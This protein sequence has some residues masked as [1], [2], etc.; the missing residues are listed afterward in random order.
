MHKKLKTRYLN[1]IKENKSFLVNRSFRFVGIPFLGIIVYL[2]IYVIHPNKD[3]GNIEQTWIH[4]LGDIILSIIIAVVIWEG[5]LILNKQIDKFYNWKEQPLKRLLSQI[6]L[7]SIYSTLITLSFTL[8]YL[9][10]IVHCP[11]SLVYDELKLI[12]FIAVIIFLLVDIVY[13]G[14]YFFRQ[15]EQMTMEAEKLKQQNLISQYEALKNQVNPHF[16]FNS[17]NALTTL[18]A[19]D[20][21][22]AIEFVQRISNVYR[23]VL[24]NKDKELIKLTEE[25]QFIKAF[26]FLQKI[27][28]GDNLNVNFAIPDCID[29]YLI[30]PLTLQ[31]LVENAIKHNIISREKP[32]Y[33]S[34]AFDCDSQLIVKNNIQKKNSPNGSIGI[35]LKNI[36]ERYRLLMNKVVTI[37]EIN[38]EFV[39]SVPLIKENKKYESINN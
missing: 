26:L 12:V 35:G 18:I 19:E 13:I 15:W 24:Q 4:F 9:E 38:N 5:S 27:R 10:F 34:I 21:N 30:A 1:Y 32:L 25:I 29:S 33:I 20:Q 17:L 31:M 28:F 8:F 22:L 39:V 3:F 16:L 14:A 7:N 6:A 2:I 23:Y 37:A 11:V 36:S